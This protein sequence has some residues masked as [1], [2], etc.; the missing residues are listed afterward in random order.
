MQEE[1]KSTP[2]EAA[3]W[4]A[5]HDIGVERDTVDGF[6]LTAPVVWLANDGDPYYTQ[7]FKD[8]NEVEEFVTKLRA[9]ADEA[10]GKATPTE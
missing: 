9:A 8:H 6:K 7:Y 3:Y 2:E 5:R 1:H 4:S 10:F